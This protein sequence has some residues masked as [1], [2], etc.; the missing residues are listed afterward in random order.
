MKIGRIKG[1]YNIRQQDLKST[2]RKWRNRKQTTKYR[3]GLLCFMLV[4]AILTPHILVA[5]AEVKQQ[6]LY[7]G[8]IDGN[9]CISVTDLSALNQAVNGRITLTADQKK[10]ADLNG[11]GLITDIDLEL[12]NRYV[13]KEITEFP[14]ERQLASIRITK[15]PDKLSYT[16]FTAVDLRGMVVTAYYNNGASKVVTDYR[17]DGNASAVGRQRI[18]VSYTEAGIKKSDCF[19]IQVTEEK[20]EKKT[21]T[22]HANGGSGAPA[23]QSAEVNAT[24]KISAVIPQKYFI[25]TL[26]ADGGSVSSNY[27]KIQARFTGWS[28]NRNGTGTRYLSGADLKLDRDITLY[29]CYEGAALGNVPTPNKSGYL[30]KGWYCDNTKVSANTKITGNCQLAARWEKKNES[31]PTEKPDTGDDT[32]KPVQNNSQSGSQENQQQ[33]GQDTYGDAETTNNEQ[34]NNGTDNGQQNNSDSNNGQSGNQPVN[35]EITNGQQNNNDAS[36][37]D[38]WGA[39]RGE[40]DGWND[41]LWQDETGGLDIV[42]DRTDMEDRESGNQGSFDSGEES[43]I[44]NGGLSDTGLDNAGDLGVI[45]GGQ[46]DKNMETGWQNNGNQG[47][48]SDGVNTENTKNPNQDTDDE[49][50]DTDDGYYDV[51][52]NVSSAVLQKGKSTTAVQAY[53]TGEDEIIR[54]QSSNYSVAAVNAKGKIKAKKVGSAVITVKTKHGCTAKVRI[55]VQ[56]KA[57]ITKKLKTN[58]KKV[59][60]KV[61]KTF[62]I[63]AEVTPITSSQGIK[64]MS[65]NPKVASVSRNG[66][67]KARKKGAAIVKVKSGKKVVKV[68]VIVK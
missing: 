56:K 28:A 22:Y 32:K 10:R 46:G 48:Y 35:T 64:Y 36:V 8:D 39:D 4:T 19:Y 55:K 68:K 21:L 6:G 25:V 20:K 66:R 13:L 37:V 53:V 23:A 29:A 41:D 65:S 30:F 49:E 60:M 7:Y 51:E 47:E 57:V 33:T 11:D 61:G 44:E 63:E 18:Q 9:G 54:Y 27:L 43:S 12:M 62:D 15:Q 67:I 3:K 40:S 59:S 50:S 45:S 34:G 2:W 31:V 14:V 58:T 5:K 1:A 26:N 16:I 17:I 52:W 38:E 24:V 42:P